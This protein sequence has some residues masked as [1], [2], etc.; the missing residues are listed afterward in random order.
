MISETFKN[1]TVF[2][3]FKTKFFD[4]DFDLKVHKYSLSD[5][6]MLHVFNLRIRNF[7]ASTEGSIFTQETRKKTIITEQLE[8]D[9]ENIINSHTSNEEMREDPKALMVKWQDGKLMEVENKANH[10]N[11]NEFFKAETLFYKSRRKLII[12]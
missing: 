8:V 9:Y 2:S 3:T 12:F 11:Q 6:K 4:I 1:N 7:S 5:N 10:S